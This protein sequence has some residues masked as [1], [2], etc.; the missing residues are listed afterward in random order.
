MVMSSNP[1]F[2]KRKRGPKAEKSAEEKRSFWAHLWIAV[3]G[4]AALAGGVFAA[5]LNPHCE[6]H[7]CGSFALYDPWILRLERGAATSVLAVVIFAILWRVIVFG[8]FPSK[9][10]GNSLEWTEATRTLKDSVK[11]LDRTVKSLDKDVKAQDARI[12]RLADTTA[13]VFRSLVNR[14]RR[15][16]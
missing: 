16:E 14:P 13:K 3:L 7:T 10:S 15:D 5:L 2:E 11:R 6:G 1:P 9:I 4:L 12:T 8:E